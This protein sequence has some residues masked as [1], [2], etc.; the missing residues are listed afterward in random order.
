MN[1]K[2]LTVYAI[3]DDQ[4]QK[5][6]AKIQGEIKKLGLVGSQT[7]MPFHISL[8]SYKA[9]MES[10]LI[11]KIKQVCKENMCFDLNLSKINSFGSRVLFVEPE[12]NQNLLDLRKIFNHDFN[13]NFD[14]HAHITL[15]ID[16]LGG[17]FEQ[18]K[19][20]ASKLFV[21]SQA[22]IVGISMGEFFPKRDIVEENLQK[23]NYEQ[24]F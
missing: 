5:E 9:D 17:Q 21:K 24:K 13:P 1:D 12:I 14:W 19:E 15:F 22:K 4:T 18:A 8:G 10:E 23:D 11:E 20:I 16:D 2:F 6:L 7:N 3:L